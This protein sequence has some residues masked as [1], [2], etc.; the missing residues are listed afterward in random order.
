[1]AALS[2]LLTAGSNGRKKQPFFIF[3]KKKEPL[4][5]PLS[6]GSRTGRITAKKAS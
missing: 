4:F 5:L 1:M 2:C 3:H 6:A